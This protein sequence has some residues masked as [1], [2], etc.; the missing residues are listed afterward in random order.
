MALHNEIEFEKEICDHLVSHGWLYQEGVADDFDR[1]L[2]LYP[3]DLF[4]WLEDSQE[5]AWQTYRQKNGSKAEA[6]LLQRIRDQLNQ[7]GTLDLRQEIG[8]WAFQAAQACRVQARTWTQPEI[9]VVT[10][11]TG[12]AS[13]ADRLT[14]QPKQHRPGS[15][16][17]WHPHCHCRTKD[18]QHAEH[19]RRDLAI[20]SRP[21][22]KTPRSNSRAFT[23]LRERSTCALRRQYPRGGDDHQARGQ[24]NTLPSLQQ[25]IRSKAATTAVQGI[26]LRQT[27]TQR[28]TSGR[29]FGSAK[30][31][32]RFLV[33]TALLSATKKSR[34]HGSSSPDTTSW[35]SHACCKRQS[36]KRAQVRSI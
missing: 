17:Q 26:P 7:L 1:K 31:F 27:T 15:F 9:L 25:G 36:F 10:T 20:Q 23:D 4:S 33:A 19:C 29:R 21:Q 30:A 8:A 24:R 16:P 2:A 5:E 3:P 34:S 32:L 14:P 12:F 18:R 28:H 35:P 22:P 11:P 6:Q 13:S